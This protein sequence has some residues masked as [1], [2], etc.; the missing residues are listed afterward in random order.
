MAAVSQR[1]ARRFTQMMHVQ[2]PCKDQG[3]IALQAGWLTDLKRELIASGPLHEQP[4]L[5]RQLR[6]S[7]FQTE[8]KLG[9]RDGDSAT[10]QWGVAK[11]RRLPSKRT[12]KGRLPSVLLT[13]LQFR[14]KSC[15]FFSI[16]YLGHS[17]LVCLDNQQNFVIC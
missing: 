17:I 2:Y 12:I 11:I 10:S 15:V 13:E 1:L 8:P 6:R 9:I 14:V 4:Y 5:K 7:G 3:W 16:C